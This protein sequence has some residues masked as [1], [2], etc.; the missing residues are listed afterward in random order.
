MKIHHFNGIYQERWGF[1]WA[2]LVSGRVDP[3]WVLLVLKFGILRHI[4][5]GHM[6]LCINIYISNYMYPLEIQPPCFIHFGLR[7]SMFQV[8]MFHHLKGIE[9]KHIFF[10]M[11]FDFQ[12]IHILCSIS[13]KLQR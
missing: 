12:G 9:R 4:I 13:L 8:R 7:T 11:M 3:S 5:Y 10:R 1:S 6:Y 2:M